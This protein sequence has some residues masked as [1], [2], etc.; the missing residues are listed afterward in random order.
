MEKLDDRKIEDLHGRTEIV[1]KHFRDLFTDTT[2]EVKPEWIERRWPRETLDALPVID[3]ERIREIT[4]AFRKRTLCAED[5]VVI[6]M[7]R[8]RDAD[9]WDTVAKCF[10]YRFLNH[11][12]EGSDKMWK[13]QLATIF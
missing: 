6:E 4:W 10:Q 11:W 8:E 1:H 2:N 5:Q 7:L 3:G 9:V 13:T 12:T